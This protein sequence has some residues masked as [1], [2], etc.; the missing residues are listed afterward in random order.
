M[1]EGV[2]V[3]NISNQYIVETQDDKKYEC[4]AKGKLKIEDISPV[5]GDRVQ[6]D[7][8]ENEPNKAMIKHILQRKNYI[9]R[10]KLANLT[11]II[12]VVSLKMPKPDLLLL[13]KQLAFAEFLRIKPMIILNKTDLEKAEKVEE[14]KQ[15]YTQIGYQVILTN[16]KEKIGI[17]E[18]KQN[19]KGQISAF[20]GNSGVGKSTL[21]NGI[22]EKE[23]TKEGDISR[24]NKK[25][26]NTTTDICLYK[27][28]QQTYIADTPGF[29]TFDIYE[30]PKEELYQYF[31]ELKMYEK[32]CKFVGCTHIKEQECGIKEALQ[33]GKIADSRYQNYCKIYRH[34]RDREEHKW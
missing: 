1:L 10:P 5:V 20:S 3:S 21:L 12:L 9:K 30:I 7:L 4:G 16:A 34:L 24:K 31:I 2:I 18:I 17:K 11:R 14:I 23:Q 22:F 29:S 28:D 19:L 8:I 32:H 33:Q 26:K 15:I 27:I 13:D 6:I 25:G